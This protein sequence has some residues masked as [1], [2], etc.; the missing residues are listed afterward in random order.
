MYSIKISYSTGNSFGSHDEI[1]FLDLTW[2]N[3]DIAKENLRAIKEH[4]DMYN[5][6]EGYSTR[7]NAY[8]HIL[9]NSDREWF[10]NVQKLFCKSQNRAIDE[11]QKS[12]YVDDW[13]YR[14]DAD[15]ATNCLKLKTDNGKLMQM[16][17]FW[18]GYFEQL[19]EVEIVLLDTDMKISFY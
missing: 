5:L 8:K 13:E 15:F 11:K 7:K 18:C 17:A 9:D 3:L 14:I 2:S 19:Q 10:V 6:I 1:D 12:M 4:H 16:S